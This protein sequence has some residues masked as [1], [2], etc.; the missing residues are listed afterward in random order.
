MQVESR[1]GSAPAIRIIVRPRSHREAIVGAARFQRFTSQPQGY[2]FGG[3][4]EK[5]NPDLSG[6]RAQN[7][8]LALPMWSPFSRWKKRRGKGWVG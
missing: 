2:R 7:H 3:L 1:T 4:P 5:K 8:C 6:F